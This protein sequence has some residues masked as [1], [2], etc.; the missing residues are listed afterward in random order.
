MN[1]NHRVFVL[2]H[3]KDNL[4]QYHFQ[5][6]RETTMN[7][8]KRTRVVPIFTSHEC[9]CICLADL[10]KQN[11]EFDKNTIKTVLIPI[12]DLFNYFVNYYFQ[13]QIEINDNVETILT[14]HALTDNPNFR[15]RLIRGISCYTFLQDINN[16][17]NFKTVELDFT[18][19]KM[20]KL[21]EGNFHYEMREREAADKFNSYVLDYL[22]LLVKENKEMNEKVVLRDEVKNKMNER[23]KEMLMGEMNLLLHA[24]MRKEGGALNYP[25]LINKYF[26][27]IFYFGK[28]LNN[29]QLPYE[30]FHLIIS[31]IGE[32]SHAL[33]FIQLNK[34][35]FNYH[36]NYHY[37]FIP[38]KIKTNLSLFLTN[39]KI[40]LQKRKLKILNKLNNLLNKKTNELKMLIKIDKI[41]IEKE[42]EWKRW[43]KKLAKDYNENIIDK[44]HE[45]FSQVIYTPI[46][47]SMH[48]PYKET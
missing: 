37:L 47:K 30:I 12:R 32:L 26:V 31:F 2:A 28:V 18:K 11:L 42:Q 7:G 16:N 8:N 13:R 46:N 9:A 33:S 41:K 38:L 20:K 23:E 10:E 40:S 36:Y 17:N 27:I 45:L 15:N 6:E 39:N 5:F 21:L 24:A 4:P 48:Y 22:G 1:E 25:H 14:L 3:M 29:L 35:I 43:I 44:L 19:S 34:E